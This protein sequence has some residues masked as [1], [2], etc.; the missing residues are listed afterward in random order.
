[1]IP[2]KITGNKYV[3]ADFVVRMAR[4]TSFVDILKGTS[5]FYQL[6]VDSLNINHKKLDK[7]EQ[8]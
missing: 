7:L 3:T 4:R 1:M 8:E 6:S 5:H 2:V